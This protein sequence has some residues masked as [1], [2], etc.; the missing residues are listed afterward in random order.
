MT[1]N[2]THS[3]TNRI[4]A[5]ACALV[6]PAALIATDYSKYYDREH[7]VKLT[8]VAEP[9][10]P[11]YEVSITDFGGVGDGV[12]MNTEAFARAMAHLAEKGGGKLNVPG[13][14]WHTGPISFESNVEL[15]LDRGALVMFS[16]NLA[17]YPVSPSDWEGVPTYRA[18]S[19]LSA[20]GKHDIAITGFGT[21]NGNGQCWRPVKRAKT[22]S[23]QW[24]ALTAK[25]CV[26][27]KG[28]VWFPN[29][30][31]REVY[32]DKALQNEIHTAD[33][34]RLAYFH[35]FL[36]P[37]LLSFIECENVLLRDATFE[38]SPAWNIHPLLCE[39]LIIDNVNIRNPWYAQNGDGLDVESCNRV[40]VVNSRFDV[41][42]DAI[43]VKAGRD[44]EGRDRGVPCRDVLIEGC[45][46]YH[47]HGGFVVGSEMSGGCRDIVVNDCL[48]IGTDVGLRFKS[49][50]GRGGVVENIHIND[51][52]MTDIAGDALTF[53]LYYGIKPGAP[54][55]PVSEETPQFRNI[56]MSNISCRGAGRAAH[57]NGLPEMPVQNITL[58]NS[59]FSA[60]KGFHM[61]YTDGLTLNNV[62]IDTPEEPYTQGEGVTNLS[63]D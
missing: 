36:R 63:I 23:A 35:D 22:T 2:L 53:N 10:I 9:S 13:G 15:H 14:I 59:R 29:E 52:K 56:H 19:P 16:E 12:T 54:V 40:L 51:I 49:T 17:D 28:D 45:T 8:P 31:V 11:S 6:L 27:E 33:S 21:F 7:P 50:R 60:T 20:R 47:G 48:F 41:G 26:N 32:S 30:R 24:A 57:F 37:V 39:N 18:K 25:G 38:N 42:D 4:I 34:A 62:A 1:L 44:K 61:A 43:C 3:A 5:A 58:S 55:P 46:V